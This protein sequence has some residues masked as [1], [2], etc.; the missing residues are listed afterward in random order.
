MRR[1]KNVEHFPPFRSK[2]CQSSGTLAPSMPSIHTGRWETVSDVSQNFCGN[3]W[4]PECGLRIGA[5]GSIMSMPFMAKTCLYEPGF[6][7]MFKPLPPPIGRPQEP[8]SNGPSGHE[9]PSKC[10]QNIFGMWYQQLTRKNR[11]FH[12]QIPEDPAIIQMP[13]TSQEIPKRRHVISILWASLIL[14]SRPALIATA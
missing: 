5:Q 10:I 13:Q 2:K 8:K 6:G 7:K 14:I 12:Q 1:Q 3:T 4:L 11:G 9:V